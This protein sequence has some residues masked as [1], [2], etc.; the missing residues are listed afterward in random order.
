MPA[1]A[2]AKGVISGGALHRHTTDS[3]TG[4]AVTVGSGDG[5]GVGAAVGVAVGSAAQATEWAARRASARI[6][7]LLN[8]FTYL[9]GK[10]LEAA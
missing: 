4:A 5:V 8:V 2:I 6:A 1:A 7:A 10:G 3:S 9:C